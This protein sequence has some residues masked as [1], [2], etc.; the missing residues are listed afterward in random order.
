MSISIHTSISRKPLR[1]H[2]VVKQA[3]PEKTR[4]RKSHNDA[5]A[6]SDIGFVTLLCPFGT[7]AIAESGAL[8]CFLTA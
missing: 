8:K 7:V 6:P 2:D 3:I 5:T 4:R 1:S